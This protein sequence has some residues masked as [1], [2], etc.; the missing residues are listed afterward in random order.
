MVYNKEN[1][2][3]LLDLDSYYITTPKG[4][5]PL[6][7]IAKIE[8]NIEPTVITREGLNYTVDIL[9]Y[10]EKAAISHI[11]ESFKEVMEKSKGKLPPGYEISQEGDVKQ[12]MDSM[13]RMFKAIGIGIILLFFA[14]VPPFRSFS[15]PIAVIFAVPLLLFHRQE[16]Y[17]YLLS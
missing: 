11:M 9:G 5:I 1:R 8:K 17:D 13:G 12:M 4:N 14:L 16:L 7:A 2:D 6:S 10:R 3:S 15:A